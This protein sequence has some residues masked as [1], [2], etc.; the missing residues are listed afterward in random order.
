MPSP[1][2]RT[3]E[4]IDK[5]DPDGIEALRLLIVEFSTRQDK[6]AALTEASAAVVLKPVNPG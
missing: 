4:L 2:Q 3:K 5:L 1:R 6:A